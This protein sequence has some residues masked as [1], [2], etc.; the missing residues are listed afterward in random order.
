[1]IKR[2]VS[3]LY[4]VVIAVMAI[5]TIIEKYQGT[6][7]VSE[8]IYGAWWFSALWAVLTAFAIVYFLK[9]KVRRWSTIA[10]HLSFVLILAGA[11]LTHLTASQGTLHLRQGE[12]TKDKALPFSI[13]LDKFNINY[14]E[15][16]MAASNYVSQ[17]TVID[18]DSEVKG[19]TSMNS[20]F[21]HRGIRLYQSGY[22]P[23]ERGAYL[24]Y[25]SDPWG[26]PVTY[27]AYGLLFLSLVWI[28]L[29]PKGRFRQI[30]RE[31]SRNNGMTKPRN[32]S[33]PTSRKTALMI[34][35]LMLSAGSASAQ[36]TLPRETAEDFG[37]L[38]VVYNN[39][40]SPLQTFALDFTKK[41]CGKRSYNG[42][43]AEQVLAGFIF[44]PDDWS[45]EPIIKV[46]GGAMKD[47][48][49]LP[50]MCSVNTFFNH[51]MGGYIL[52]PYLREA[53]NGNNDAFH[54]DVMKMDDRLMLIMELRQ[55]K[56]LTLFPYKSG[57]PW[58]S[59]TDKLP[60]EMTAEN[61]TFIQNVFNLL[62]EDALSGNWQ[63]FS[64][65]V[66][67]MKKYQEKYGAAS[68]PT[69]TQ[70]KAERLYNSVPFATILFM[71][72]LTMAFLSVI[73]RR[74]VQ[75][76]SIGILALS[77]AALTL[78]MALRW[79]ISGTIP[80]ANGY[81]TM[82]LMA[83]M[84]QLM[85]LLLCRR[86]PII[87]TFGLLMSGFF[88]LVSHISQMDPKISHVMPVLSSP[89]LSLHVSIIMMAFALLSLTFIIGIFSL[90]MPKNT[91]L[92]TQNYKLSILFLFP[93]MT[94][95]GFGIFIGAI[96]ANISWGTYWSWDPKEVWALITFMIYGI[97]LHDKSLPWLR[98]PKHYHLFM[99][100]AFLTILMTYF[101]V[102][103]FLG[104]MHSYA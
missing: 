1:M 14:H 26:I 28:L 91:E 72:C 34:A 82:L 99:V 83:W 37:R 6:Q 45:K 70:T 74:P 48:L 27:T 95:L 57:T 92:S 18:N 58:L 36:R 86:F 59:P 21:S 60:E 17:F 80:M 47:R 52:G 24:S 75:W 44:F 61:K 100:F 62:F 42:F 84:I 43:S 93:A 69:A 39:R 2:I 33:T 11:L 10:L 56:P 71:V 85:S 32:N 16:T 9:R 8:N 29:D 66:A 30:L 104:G 101:G 54:K 88:L 31:A 20:I 64:N 102:N 12:V 67:G 68:L 87:V 79:I 5:A 4:I 15:G 63:H 103:Y 3:T 81:E 76:L 51:D 38:Y 90:V 40:V 50:D 23:D 22:D 65:I 96:W 77:F 46:K 55:G 7:F 25:N 89:L 94:C 13:R 98:N 19:E 73:R 53:Y 78:C 35:A 97:A 41:L 49:Q